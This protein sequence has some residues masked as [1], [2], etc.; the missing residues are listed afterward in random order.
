MQLGD[1]SLS[2][3]GVSVEELEA[4]QEAEEIQR[5]KRLRDEFAMAALPSVYSFAK[6]NDALEYIAAR[7]YSMA[8]AMI[9]ERQK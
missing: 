3:E 2:I 8:D 5:H 4:Q 1:M 9:A 7:A 6:P